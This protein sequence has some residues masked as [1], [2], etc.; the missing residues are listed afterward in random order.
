MLRVTN[1]FGE[2]TCSADVT[3]IYEPPTFT[4]P[5]VDM[6]V[7]LT[8]TATFE[9]TFAGIPQPEPK[10]YISGVDVWEC[11]KYHVESH[12]MITSLTVSQVTMDDTEMEYLCKITNPVGE[13]KTTAKMLPQG[14]SLVLSLCFIVFVLYHGLLACVMLEVNSSSVTKRSLLIVY[15]I[16]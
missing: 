16:Y 2:C 11:E 9:C 12:E 14:L 13:A 8:D 6:S 3:I 15:P 7:M 1:E 10:W 4:K 5:L